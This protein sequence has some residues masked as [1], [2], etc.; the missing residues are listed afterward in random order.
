MVYF[1]LV[2]IQN[3]AVMSEVP[4]MV[5]VIKKRDSASADPVSPAARVK[6]KFPY[7]GS[8]LTTTLFMLCMANLKDHIYLISDVSCCNVFLPIEC[9][10]LCFNWRGN[11]VPAVCQ[12]YRGG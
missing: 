12:L 9:D 11:F 1:F 10:L 8:I 3:V 4:F 2:F 5:S 7:H 6:C